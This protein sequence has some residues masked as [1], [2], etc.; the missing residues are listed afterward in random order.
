[1][2]DPSKSRP[3][4]IIS[5]H[6]FHF[7]LSACRHLPCPAQK[8][9]TAQQKNA[10]ALRV[11]RRQPQPSFRFATLRAIQRLPPSL[12]SQ[13]ARA[14][15]LRRQKNHS[16]IA[17]LIFL[18]APFRLKAA[19]PALFWLRPRTTPDHPP[20]KQLN[21]YFIEKYYGNIGKKS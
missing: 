14:S 21:V 1:L 12:H 9:S 20:L 3:A 5:F 7:I 13:S 2:F 11:P 17:P 8:N 16:A 4:S 15:P 10:P 19:L 6:K 18:P